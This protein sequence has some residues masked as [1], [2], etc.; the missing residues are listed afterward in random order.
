[1]PHV[2]YR[3][4]PHLAQWALYDRLVGIVHRAIR[5]TA[6]AG[7][8]LRVLEIGAGHGGYTSV[9]LAAGCE[10]TMVEMSRASV[11]SLRARYGTN[12][13]LTAIHDPE[14]D[15]T[16]VGQGYSLVVCISVLHH[17]PDYIEL[18]ERI[19]D[20]VGLGGSMLLLQEPL[21]YPRMGLLTRTV[22]RCAYLAWRLGQGN[23]G[24]GFTSM[25]RRFRGVPL[26]ARP[27][28][29]VYYHVARQGVDEEAVCR[30]LERRFTSVEPLPY[31]SNHLAAIRRPAELAGMT[32]TFGIRATGF[33]R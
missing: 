20:H 9:L 25:W 19:T 29:I 13:R 1:M 28:Q 24:D 10:V 3:H 27:G 8:P 2:D 32:N 12:E 30:F 5:A 33:T 11:E 26:E 16:D 6:D 31:W 15:L 18:L 14:A 7:L 22:D 17:I 4:S 23:V 21:W